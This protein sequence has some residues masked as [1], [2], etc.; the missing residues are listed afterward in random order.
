MKL[1]QVLLIN[2]ATVAVAL[3][4]YDELRD[5]AVAQSRVRAPTS[6]S[7]REVELEARV[8]A[9]EVEARTLR[10]AAGAERRVPDPMDAPAK[11]GALRASPEAE[12]GAAIDRG[13]ATKAPKA[14]MADQPSSEDVDRFRRLQDAVRRENSI[15]KNRQRVDGALDKLS[16]NLTPKQRERVHAAVAEF[17]PNI[18]RI[19][20][21]VKTEARATIEAGGEVDRGQ[22]VSSTQTRIQT[23]FAATL[24][25]IVNHQADAQAIAEA[26]HPAGRK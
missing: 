25:E 6:R 13:P 20:G 4:V 23:E 3:V 19:W 10:E 21:E 2:V 7:T 9:L 17:E 15:K 22:I 14:R 11:A 1:A 26:V 18:V 24:S 8:H 12:P 5:D 16:I